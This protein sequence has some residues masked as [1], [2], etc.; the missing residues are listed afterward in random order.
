MTKVLNGGHLKESKGFTL[1]ELLVVIAIIGLLAAV[2]LASIGSARQKGGDAAIKSSL[3][4]IRAQAELFASDNN[5]VY[6]GVCADT[7]IVSQITAAKIAANV[8]TATGNN[9]VAASATTAVCH[10]LSSGWAVAVPLLS[11]AG[12]TSWC[13]DGSGNATDTATLTASSVTCGS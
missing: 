5:N 13:V 11:N 8:T 10:E 7:K 3:D 9:T 1:I 12:A 4:G 6:T 2:V